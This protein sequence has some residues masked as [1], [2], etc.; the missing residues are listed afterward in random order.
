MRG[1]VQGSLLALDA[2]PLETVHGRFLAHRFHNLCTGQPALAVACGDLS[3]GAPLPARV[4]SSCIT[5]EAFGACDCD[6]AEQLGD[7]LATIAAAG[8][9]LLFYL[10]QEGR[11]AGFAAKALDRML[12]QASGNTVTTFEAYD[13]LGLARDHRSYDEVAWMLRL[14]G[15]SAPLEL[16]TNNPGKLDALA[17]LGVAVAGHRP[18]AVAAHSFSRHYLAAKTGVGHLLAADPGEVA[19]LPEPVERIVPSP[20]PGAPRMLTLAS[21]LLPLRARRTEWF[22]LHL[23]FDVA[24][25]RE[26]VVLAH[27]DGREPL[28]R[29]QRER[30]L[31]RFPLRDRGARG[32]WQR[33]I[34]AM[35]DAGGGAALFLPE[36][37]ALRDDDAV[38]LASRLPAARARLLGGDTAGLGTRLA[39]CGVSL[40]PPVPLAGDPPAAPALAAIG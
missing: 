2:V 37:E 21:Y 24:R 12:V 10:S 28:V 23:F 6:C 22:R 33:A 25:R 26:R 32:R 20:V 14:L 30:L 8:R 34:D 5:S 3:G 40:G 4:H 16:L 31:E 13:Q 11:G 35:V 17:E 15:V 36:G 38:L 7:A 1:E 18:L 27:G 19:E 9:G 29:V 39:R